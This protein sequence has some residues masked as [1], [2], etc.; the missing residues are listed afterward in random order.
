MSLSECFPAAVPIDLGGVAYLA[1]PLALEHLAQ[2]EAWAVAALPSP[3]AALEG[4]DPADPAYPEALRAAYRACD[5]W[6]PKLGDPAVDALVFETVEG[7]ALLALHCLR[8]DP[9]ALSAERAAELASAADRDEWRRFDRV[10]FALDPSPFV[11][12]L[13]LVNR[14]LGFADFATAGDRDGGAIPWT[15]AIAEAC[16]EWGYT[17]SQVGALTLGQWRILRSGG[18]GRERTEPEPA[19]PAVLDLYADAHARFWGHVA[20][21]A[22]DG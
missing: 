22:T 11:E 12:V 6:P 21:E 19:D 10:A 16:V 14:H 13:A 2:V 15:Q 20:Q 4:I 8:D 3:L 9:R 7:R 18:K 17:P 1:M 5:A